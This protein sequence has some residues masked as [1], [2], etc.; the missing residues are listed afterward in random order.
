MNKVIIPCGYMGS[1]SSAVTNLIEEFEGYEASN[2]SFEYIFLHCPNGVFD[3][4]DKLLVGNNALRSDEALHSFYDQ[5]KALYGNKLWW[6]ADYQHRIG[7][8]FLSIT[9]EYVESLK[10]FENNEYWYMQQKPTATRFIRLVIRKVLNCF[11][12]KSNKIKVPLNYS[13][14]WISLPSSDEFYK[15]S[16]DYIYRI[17]DLMGINNNNL[18]LDQFL[19]PFNLWRMNKYFRD[20]VECF[21]VDRDPRD[22]F[23][24]NKYIYPSIDETVPY[25]TDVECFCEY[26]RRLRSM[27]KPAESSHIHRIHF[28]DLIYKY[29]ESEKR[30]SGILGLDLSLHK[31]RFTKFNPEVSI[32]NTQVFCDSRFDEEREYIENHLK[33]FLYDFPY[34]RVGNIEKSF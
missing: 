25:P 22:I 4:E 12:S 23:I 2:G 5:M 9:E 10:E 1:G 13:P 31:N 34:E 20:N 3:L 30:I 15:K 7:E 11:R 29:D 6:V 18:I 19:L 28:E 8:D 24:T 33:E 17:F 16:Q 21:V 27:E 14:M 32:N 26:Y